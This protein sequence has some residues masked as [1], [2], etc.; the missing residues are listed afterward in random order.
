MLESMFQVLQSQETS[1][2][3][4]NELSYD[5]NQV[6]KVVDRMQLLLQFLLML[7]ISA[8]QLFD[9]LQRSRLSPWWG[10]GCVAASAPVFF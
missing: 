1:T 10:F 3:W 7:K 6:S 9:F 5:F 2:P 8:V 4:R